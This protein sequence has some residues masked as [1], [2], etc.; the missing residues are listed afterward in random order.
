MFCEKERERRGVNMMKVKNFD[1]WTIF[2]GVLQY[3]GGG[4]REE[5]NEDFAQKQAFAP[6]IKKTFS[7]LK[8][9][10]IVF[11]IQKMHHLPS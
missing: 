10:K 7:L 11:K 6:R 4:R 8:A 9:K 2:K 1:A 5:G 3:E